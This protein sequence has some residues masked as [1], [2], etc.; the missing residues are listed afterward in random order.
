MDVCP[1]AAN[2]EQEDNDQDGRG[3]DCD[4]DDD[5]DGAPDTLDNCPLN[6]NPLKG[7]AN[8]DAVGNA[9]DALVDGITI[10]GALTSQRSLAQ[11]R[12][13]HGF[14]TAVAKRHRASPPRATLSSKTRFVNLA[15]L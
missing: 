11:T 9:C 14:I 3:D 2:A 4:H 12:L 15:A 7:D 1:D 8:G 6:A 10:R 13:K 5:N